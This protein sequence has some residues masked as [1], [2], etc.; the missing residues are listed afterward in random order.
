MP[1]TVLEKATALGFRDFHKTAPGGSTWRKKLSDEWPPELKEGI[2]EA[3]RMND[4]GADVSI[5]R[6]LAWAS[7]EFPKVT[8]TKDRVREYATNT[9]G[10]KTW[11]QK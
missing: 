4:A 8:L 2:V 3:C 9:M 11:R 10:R 6:V 7:Q 1:K 5:A